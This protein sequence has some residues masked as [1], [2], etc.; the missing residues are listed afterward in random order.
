[1]KNGFEAPVIMQ[2]YPRQHRRHA[3]VRLCALTFHN[4][5]KVDK[6]R[7]NFSLNNVIHLSYR[8][9]FT[10]CRVS[11]ATTWTTETLHALNC[12]RGWA[13]TWDEG[14]TLLAS[15]TH[16]IRSYH[17]HI[18]I[19]RGIQFI[20]HST[21]HFGMTITFACADSSTPNCRKTRWKKSSNLKWNIFQVI[22]TSW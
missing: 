13:R 17:E 7:V 14:R 6:R 1:M 4:M 3:W 16:R 15:I 9:I 18:I 22:T 12:Q 19:L 20:F 8:Q 21:L 11:C 5:W 10:S 2:I